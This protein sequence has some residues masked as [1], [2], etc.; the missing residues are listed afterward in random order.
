[1]ARLITKLI[2][3]LAGKVGLYAVILVVLL[4]IFL[5]KFLPSM[6]VN[7]H[8]EQLEK[9]VAELSQSRALVGELADQVKQI[10]KQMDEKR[11]E[12]REL[13]A[14]HQ[15]LDEFLQKVLN[16]FRRDEVLAEQKRIEAEQIKL[17]KEVSEHAATRRA[18]RIQGGETEEELLR[19]QLLLDE[20]Q[21]QLSQMQQLR[22]SMDDLMKNQLK[23]LAIQAFYILL[24]LIL[25]PLLWKVA[26]YYLFAPVVQNSKPITIGESIFGSE[27]ISVTPSHPAQR[28][29]LNQNEVMLTRVD[30]LQ[31][32]MGDF[33][34]GTKWLMDW[35]YPFSSLAAGLFILTK[36]QNAGEETGD[37]TLS[38]QEDATEELS[39]VEIPEGVSLVFRPNFLIAVCHPV[40]NPPRIRSKW[41]FRKLHAWVNLQFRY[42][43]VDGP[44]RLV[45]SAQRGIQV[46]DVSE[47]S[48]G[49]RVNTRLVVAFSPQ[50]KYSPRRAETFVAYLWGKNA[51]F[52]DYFQGAGTVIQQQV[53]GG[54]RNPIARLWESVFG[55]IGKAFGI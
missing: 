35:R 9:A 41:V 51:L 8:E 43:I 18:I 44:T 3:W 34:K 27:K 52:D 20:K 39:V 29:H 38:T 30:Y 25:I 46:E 55:A 12:L 6:I 24:S 14:K 47:S 23:H 53:T 22:A 10:T 15:R 17:R 50:L 13:E 11:Q 33:E 21:K 36:I 42:L 32:S 54:K 16:L 26:A 40:G 45:F 31:G 37:V 19:R 48:L 5:V 28:L 7:H 4:A 1:M 49:R 2:S